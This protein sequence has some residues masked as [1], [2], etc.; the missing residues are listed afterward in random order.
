MNCLSRG[1]ARE[2]LTNWLGRPLH[3]DLDSSRVLHRVHY[4]IFSHVELTYNY[5]FLF[6]FMRAKNS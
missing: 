3:V 4:A 1:V 6:Y 5:L 2:A